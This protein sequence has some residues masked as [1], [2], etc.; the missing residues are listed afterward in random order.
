MIA[1]H[2]Q[3]HAAFTL[4]EALVVIE[5][6]AVLLGL[7]LPA[8]QK[9]RERAS[10]A[11]CINNLRQLSLAI[12]QFHDTEKRL[13][14]G[15]F[16][17]EFGT[18]SNSRAWSFLAR[19]LPFLEQRSIFEQGGIPNK[20]LKES[21]IADVSIG[22]F[23]CPSDPSDQTAPQFDAGNLSGFPV[24]VTNYKGVS[25]ANWG[26]DLQGVAG[27]TFPTDWRNKGTNGS[28]DG[29]SQG[30]GMFFRVD[31]RRRLRLNEIM[32]GTSNT[33]ML[34]EDLPGQ[35]K[36]C[37]W[38]YSNNAY[39]TCAIPPNVRKPNGDFYPPQNWQNTW[40]FRSHH[41]GGVHFSAA[42]ASVRFVSQSIALPTYRALATISGGETA[43]IP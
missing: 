30:D 38:P 15:Q 19:L 24:G 10:Q 8:V 11:Q 1:R 12:H 26:D 16:G 27:P 36:W 42:D 43:N 17:A 6:I 33:F 3:R 35:N 20:T 7:L 34:G 5:I 2:F 32:D 40:S 41:P 9:V 22:I 14:Y 39:G 29:L 23:H 37:S 21:R 31:F 18:G 4:I 28:F 13:P 25:G